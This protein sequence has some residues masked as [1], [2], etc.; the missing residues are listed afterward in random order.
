M[1]K[2]LYIP[3]IIHYTKEL[4]EGIETLEAVNA[5]ADV[6]RDLLSRIS[7]HLES[8]YRNTQKLESDREKAINTTDSLKSAEAFR[9]K[10]HVTMTNLREDIDMLETLIPRKLWPVPTYADLLFK[11]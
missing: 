5:S 9:D 2:S 1:V 3:A 10:V 6:Q 7:T 4:A 11:L 8:A